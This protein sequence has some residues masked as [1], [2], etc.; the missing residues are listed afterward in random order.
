MEF[1]T[2]GGRN[3]FKLDAFIY[4][5]NVGGDTSQ[6]MWSNQ[7]GGT[8]A[9]ITP[10]YMLWMTI[11]YLIP[12]ASIGISITFFNY[13]GNRQWFKWGEKSISM[14]GLGIS[15]NF[16]NSA[17]YLINL[18]GIINCNINKDVLIFILIIFSFCIYVM[19]YPFGVPNFLFG[20]YINNSI[21]LKDEPAIIF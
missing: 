11:Y 9:Q 15:M 7:V 4:S 16:I 14:I 18:I 6:V 20:E 1:K 13:K 8:V 17:I 21:K 3:S 12:W 5:K 2:W 19:Y 10:S